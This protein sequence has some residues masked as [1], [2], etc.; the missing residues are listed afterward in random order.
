MNKV[1]A[2]FEEEEKEILRLADHFDKVLIHLR[3]EGKVHRGK[4][5]S[6]ANQAISGL[7][8]ML[9]RHRNFQEEIIFPYLLI[10]IPKHESVIQFLRS[11]HQT[12]R[13]SKKKLCLL[14]S[15]LS[16]TTTYAHDSKIQE[17]GIYL[18]YLI[19]HHIELERTSI[20]KAIENELNADEK[21]EVG[22]K[23]RNWLAR[24]ADDYALA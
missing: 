8:Q 14:L 24:H 19:R 10:H 18:I 11:D 2:F 20:H 12:I 17:L 1:L 6:A 9:R 15:K 3:F 16:E 5:I 13:Q 4:N 21:K 22:K 23:V 7:V